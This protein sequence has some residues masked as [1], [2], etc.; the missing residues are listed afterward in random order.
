MAHP[1]SIT[2]YHSLL[3]SGVLSKR[4]LQ[5]TDW[6]AHHQPITAKDCIEQ[7]RAAGIGIS[8]QSHTRFT[9][10]AGMRVIHEVGTRICPQSKQP[11]ALWALTGHVPTKKAPT[12]PTGPKRP[13]KDD[14]RKAV[15]EIR[16]GIPAPSG[17]LKALNEWLAWISKLPEVPKLEAPE[18]DVADA[19]VGD[20]DWLIIE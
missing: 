12:A 5:V 13:S 3:N 6:I 1:N 15:G 2:T 11:N 16:K 8:T 9:E 4:Q 18:P 10:L 14:I 19:G 17:E 20:L 7:M